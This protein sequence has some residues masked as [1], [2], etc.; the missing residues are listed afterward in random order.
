MCVFLV[1][2]IRLRRL[3]L[4]ILLMIRLGRGSLAR[5][6]F[7]LS[8]SCG[9]FWLLVLV[10]GTRRRVKCR[11]ILRVVKVVACRFRVGRARRLF[12]LLPSCKN[13]VFRFMLLLWL[14]CPL[15]LCRWVTRLILV[16]LRRRVLFL[17][18]RLMV[19]LKVARRV[20]PLVFTRMVLPILVNRL[21]NLRNP[22]VNERVLVLKVLCLL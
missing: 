14:G 6:W 11:L 10:V 3:V 12:V 2:L 13:V 4:R 16:V 17:V 20:T 22:R 1:Y 7:R 9:V 21:K 8:R 19:T 15:G 5:N 18:F